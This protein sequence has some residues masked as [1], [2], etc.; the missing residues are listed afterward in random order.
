MNDDVENIN[1][2][3]MMYVNVNTMIIGFLTMTMHAYK[4]GNL[5]MQAG[6]EMLEISQSYKFP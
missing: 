5:N 2:M 6:L 3:I 1:I 4:K